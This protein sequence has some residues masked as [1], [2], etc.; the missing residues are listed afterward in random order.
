MYTD[1]PAL[2]RLRDKINAIFTA[3]S[4]GSD[5]IRGDAAHAATKSDHN[6]GNAL[7]VTL[8]AVNGP[9]LPD[10]KAA[11]LTDPRVTYIIFNGEIQSRIKEPGV[12]RPYTGVNAHKHHLH[13]SIDPAQ[14]NDTRD[15]DLSGVGLGS[16]GAP[17]ALS[18]ATSGGGATSTSPGGLA[19]SWVPAILIALSGV[20]VFWAVVSGFGLTPKTSVLGAL[21]S[22]PSRWDIADA[23]KHADREHEGWT[24]EDFDLRFEG[25][26]TV[27]ELRRFDHLGW[28]D[29]DKDDRARMSIEEKFHALRESRGLTWSERAKSWLVTGVPP[30]VVITAP[31]VDSRGSGAMQTQIG[32]GR[33]RTN[34]A[35]LMGVKIPVWHAVYRGA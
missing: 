21:A 25:D 32:D 26:L 19:V 5:G 27:G 17:T 33:G 23:I 16:P 22:G 9:N 18:P 34:F 7:D 12:S 13:V 10:L 14:R 30:I 15:W 11:L 8:D 3:R 4:R 1:A 28:I 6:E 31:G 24:L 20:A 29:F 35:V 2:L